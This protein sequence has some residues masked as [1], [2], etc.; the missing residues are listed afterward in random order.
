METLR[1]TQK[2]AHAEWVKNPSAANEAALSAATAAVA[3]AK[4]A[5]AAVVVVDTAAIDAVAARQA[6]NASAEAS[7]L[8]LNRAGYLYQCAQE[9]P[10]CGQ[11]WPMSRAECAADA[12]LRANPEFSQGVEE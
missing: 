7:R 2:E 4:R 9:W 11:N 1:K 5:A 6:A 10:R 3:A 8:A 12:L